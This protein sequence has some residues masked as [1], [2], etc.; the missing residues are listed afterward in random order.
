MLGR[1]HRALPGRAGDD[2]SATSTGTAPRV[3]RIRVAGA[4][5]HSTGE[6]PVVA[7]G[8]TPPG[9]RQP[10]AAVGAPF[11]AETLTDEP[12]SPLIPRPA[13]A[14]D[15]KDDDATLTPSRG[16]L[17]AVRAALR[18]IADG[19]LLVEVPDDAVVIV[20][21]VERGR[22]VVRVRELDR[23]ARHVVRIL[24]L[25]YHSWSG[26]VSL[27]GLPAARVRPTL[28]PRAR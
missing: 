1:G 16:A 25:G 4:S 15:D 18:G 23:H 20:N 28:R 27:D 17:E 5:D 2:D 22:G 12:R 6:D 9:R 14:G 26:S 13:A 21:G 19:V 24:R 10:A 11:A 7:G 3:T 8:D